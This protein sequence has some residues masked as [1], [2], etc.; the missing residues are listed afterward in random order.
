MSLPLIVRERAET[1]IRVAHEEFE[2]IRT[3]LGLRFAS[4]V[5]ETFEHIEAMPEMYGL[6]WQDVRAA[7]LKQFRHI[8]YYIVFVD[9][10][11]VLA[12]MHGARHDSAWQSRVEVEE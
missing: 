9:R 5:R 6:V 7:R 1:D 8:V 12:V 2:T 10:I 11:E 3:G 4:R